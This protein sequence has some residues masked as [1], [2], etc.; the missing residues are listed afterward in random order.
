LSKK[1]FLKIIKDGAILLVDL[2]QF[3]FS[4]LKN[5]IIQ[6]LVTILKTESL[7]WTNDNRKKMFAANGSGSKTSDY[8]L[9][10]ARIAKANRLTVGITT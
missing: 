5:Y 10:S 4:Q 7:K 8:A 3:I 6:D 9:L 2:K 1:T